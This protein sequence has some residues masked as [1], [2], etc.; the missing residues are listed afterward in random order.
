MAHVGALLSVLGENI[1][2]KERTGV[3]GIMRAEP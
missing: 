3:N 2:D 1:V